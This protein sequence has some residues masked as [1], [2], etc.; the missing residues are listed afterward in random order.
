[1]KGCIHLYTGTGK[2]KTTC[3]VGVSV[4]AAGSGLPVWFVQFLKSAPSGEVDVLRK[5]PNITMLRHEG[6]GKFSWQ[7][8]DS[9][10]R[11]M[12]RSHHEFLREAFSQ[13]NYHEMAVLVLDEIL[14]AC[15]IGMVEWEYLLD[16]LQTRGD[17]VEVIL[18]GRHAPTWL[19]EMADYHTEMTKKRHP[20]D[21]G[22]AGRKGIEW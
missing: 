17:G 21:Q 1:M 13:A 10:K 5:I 4:R 9:E 14:D 7:M 3:S 6:S 20:F 12:A 22:I 11:E 15:E 16:L 18:T 8:D 2:G 19:E